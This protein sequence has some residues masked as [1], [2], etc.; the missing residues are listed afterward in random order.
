MRIAFVSDVVFPYTLGGMEATEYQYA[1]AL[2]KEHEVYFFSLQFEGME[3]EFMKDG[4]HYIGVAKARK[5][6][7]YNSKGQRSIRLAM[8]F[9]KSLIPAMR[10]YEFDVVIANSFP[11]LHLNALK[12]SIKCPLVLDV[13]EVWSLEQWRSYLGFAKGLIAYLYAMHAIKGADFYI[14]NSSTTKALLEKAG[15]E[16]SKIGVFSPIV[17]MVKQFHEKKKPVVAYAGRLIPEKRLDKWIDAVEAAHKL[18]PKAKGLII[19]SGPLLKELKKRIANEK[20]SYIRIIK[21]VPREKLYE[22]L[23]SSSI[24]LNM[25]EREGLSATS[26]ESIAVGTPVVLPAYTPIPEEVKKMCN[27]VAEEK[28]PGM[29]AEILKSKDK[30]KYIKHKEQLKLFSIG[31]IPEFF[32][33]VFKKVGIA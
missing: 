30:Q 21:P 12:H 13:A 16:P 8:L 18:Y 6:E 3:K 9:A 7:L 10:N 17:L 24:L 33:S 23:A 1:K 5:A 4:I 32:G 22:V 27:V 15:I 20:A 31:L 2:A 19:G 29:L 25:S 26:I 28:I 14:A 11:I